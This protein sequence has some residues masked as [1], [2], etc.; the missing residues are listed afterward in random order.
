VFDISRLSYY[1][2]SYYNDERLHSSLGYVAPKDKLKG[3]DQQILKKRDSKLEAAREE[4]KQMPLI[5][6]SDRE[7]QYCSGI[8]QKELKHHSIELQ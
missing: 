4:R 6:H 1:Y 7:L 8:Y 5:H 2:I 3:H